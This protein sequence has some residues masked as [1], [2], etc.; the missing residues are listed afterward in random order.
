[1]PLPGWRRWPRSPTESRW[2]LP[3]CRPRTGRRP[4]RRRWPPCWTSSVAGGWCWASGPG[5]M[6]PSTVRTGTPFRLP[7]RA[8]MAWSIPSTCW[9]PC[10]AHPMAPRSRG[11]SMVPHAIRRPSASR[12]RRCS[13]PPIAR[14]CC[15]LQVRGP[16]G[17]SPHSCRRM[18]CEGGSPSPAMHDA[19][20]AEAMTCGW[21]CTCTRYRFATR[22][23]P[24]GGSPPR[25]TR[26]GRRRGCS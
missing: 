17:C 15:G 5:R 8:L 14:A 3:C 1:M 21:P 10:G 20:R 22:T 6:R 24:S 16:T 19:R 2:A 7:A 13:W 23:R 12:A 9:T 11:R 26:S 25:P 4:S 18:T